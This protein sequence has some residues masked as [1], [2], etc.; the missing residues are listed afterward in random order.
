M[1]YGFNL[2]AT[3][4]AARIRE[5]RIELNS[6]FWSV[7][8]TKAAI[9]VAAGIVVAIFVR[10]VPTL[11]VLS[12]SIFLAC[13]GAFIAAFFPTW[14][15]QG[16]ENFKSLALV[17]SLWKIINGVFIVFLIR[18]PSQIP[19]LLGFCAATSL[20]FVVLAHLPAL[21]SFSARMEL[22]TLGII[23]NQLSE[24]LKVFLSQVG[25]LLYA[26]TNVFLLSVLSDQFSVG[27]YAIAE[28]IIRAASMMT[29]AISQAI[30][31]ISTRKFSQD[32]LEGLLFIQKALSLS[33]PLVFGGCVI[34]FAFPSEIVRLAS[35]EA[36]DIASQSL[37]ILAFAPLSI[38]LAN[39]FGSQILL[40][41]GKDNDYLA[42]TLISGVFS[43]ALQSLLLIPKFSALGASAGL[44]ISE[45]IILL[46]YVYRVN[47]YFGEIYFR[48]RHSA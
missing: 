4:Q 10:F 20:L 1:E 48:K 35:G 5:N 32:A 40:S 12:D 38:F 37:R 47:K 19:L 44:F 33:T 18:S 36:N 8:W 30:F 2:T 25:F 45:T 21:D 16:L 17:N 26:N 15:L 46:F 14:L 6:L 27:A 28:K 29:Y 7:F 31:P 11:N 13:A 42:G 3:R 39:T 9:G 24:G 22:P 41:K 34:L 23:Q 43:L